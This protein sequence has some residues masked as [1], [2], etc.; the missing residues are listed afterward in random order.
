MFS[1]EVKS[2]FQPSGRCRIAIFDSGNKSSVIAWLLRDAACMALFLIQQKPLKRRDGTSISLLTR[3]LL[4]GVVTPLAWLKET[5]VRLYVETMATLFL[6]LDRNFLHNGGAGP[7]VDK[8]YHLAT[9]IAFQS[10]MKATKTSSICDVKFFLNDRSTSVRQFFFNHSIDVTTPEINYFESKHGT[11]LHLSG[12]CHITLFSA[13][14]NLTFVSE[15]H[16]FSELISSC[17]GNWLYKALVKR[18]AVEKID[19]Q[20]RVNSHKV[21]L[22]K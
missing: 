8:L 18:L 17:M 22:A 14:T 4:L 6:K 10:V 9:R 21:S 12:F 11:P 20:T 16:S 3:Q 13:K 19:P 15:T 5:S 2:G 7:N 1:H